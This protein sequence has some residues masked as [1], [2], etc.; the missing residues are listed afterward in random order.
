MVPTTSFRL[1]LLIAISATLL[2]SFVPVLIRF[3]Q[4]NEATIGIVRLAIG[5]AGLALLAAFSKRKPKLSRQDWRW[6]ILLGS[7]FAVHWYAYF[8]SI[9]LADAS[10]AAIGVATFG[11]HL[12]LL[13]GLIL[14]DKLNS[15][16]LTAVAVS[17][18]GIY[19]AAPP[20]DF[21][22]TKLH[23][24]ILAV[25]SGFLYACLPLIN[26]RLGHL[27]TNTRAFGQFGFALLVFLLLLPD[28]NFQLNQT[29]WLSLAAL[30]I[31]CTLVAH[32]LWL[33]AST[34]LPPNLTAIIYYGYVPL[35]MLLS[36]IFLQESITWQKLTGAALIIGANVMVAVLHRRSIPIRKI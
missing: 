25:V 20:L 22:A 36:A 4:A 27:P 29:D 7:V 18:C 32:T 21:D 14:R 30:G 9:K 12:L 11:V 17:F 2:M 15:Y 16:D 5:A 6:L 23:G 31:V 13:N 24:F 26:R 1:L 28:A 35:T 8:R 33:K 19:I 3:T 10:L 34:E